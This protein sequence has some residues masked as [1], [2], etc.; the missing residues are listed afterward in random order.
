MIEILRERLKSSAG[1]QSVTSD[2]VS[3]TFATGGSESVR[4]QLD[5]WEKELARLTRSGGMTRTVD[6][7]KGL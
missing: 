4:A 3:T 1:I 5:Y 6:L 2:G 7:S